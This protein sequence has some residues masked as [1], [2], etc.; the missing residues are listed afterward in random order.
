MSVRVG[1][2]SHEQELAEIEASCVRTGRRAYLRD[3]AWSG[4]NVIAE[5]KADTRWIDQMCRLLD[6]QIKA[7]AR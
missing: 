6:H 4:H 3:G 5:F 2:G 7:A 1:L